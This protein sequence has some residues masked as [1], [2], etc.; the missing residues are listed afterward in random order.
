MIIAKELKL[1]A[2]TSMIANLKKVRNDAKTA[3]FGWEVDDDIAT[4]IEHAEHAYD[5]EN[6]S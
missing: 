4:L 5:E 3:G 6:D 2:I 1:M